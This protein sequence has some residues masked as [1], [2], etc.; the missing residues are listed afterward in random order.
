MNINDVLK[1]L[2]YLFYALA[3]VGF[4]VSFIIFFRLR[5]VEVIQDLTGKLTEKQIK[6]M[7][8]RSENE[9]H[10]NFGQDIL[11]SGLGETGNT[12]MTGK[13]NK[14]SKLGVTGKT[15][16]NSA[17]TYGG[18]GAAF[19][20]GSLQN[21]LQAGNAQNGTTVLQSNRVINQDFVLIK[22]IVY[23][24]TSEFI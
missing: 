16:A 1:V 6:E 5:I 20:M 9:M 19:Q 7:R 13:R 17:G 23:I 24:N 10:K 18:L 3:T 11:E 21:Q 15:N 8:A 4:I 14:A 12:G 22:N 2:T